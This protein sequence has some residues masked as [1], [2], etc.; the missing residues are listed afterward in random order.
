M[1]HL[2]PK[3]AMIAGSVALLA[4]LGI[5]SDVQA[6]SKKAHARNSV[7]TGQ[8]QSNA[9]RSSYGYQPPGAYNYQ[10]SGTYYRAA[11]GTGILGGGPAAGWSGPGG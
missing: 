4:L 2:K 6:A 10:P 11:P 7:A 3:L 5:S 1:S 9:A 8:T